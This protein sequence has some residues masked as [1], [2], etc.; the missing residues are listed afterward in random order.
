MGIKHSYNDQNPQSE[1][2]NQN[3][4]LNNE[5][6]SLIQNNKNIKYSTQPYNNNSLDIKNSSQIN[7]NNSKDNKNNK[8]IN[9]SPNVESINDKI[10][11]VKIK[12]HKNNQ[13]WEKDYKK[14]EPIGTII[15]DYMQENN[16]NIPE[17]NFNEINI[18]NKKYYI[19]DKVSAFLGN[20]E[21]KNSQNFENIE[22]NK[23]IK[24]HDIGHLFRKVVELSP[25][26]E[27]FSEL[28][29]KPFYDPFEISLFIK[30]EKKFKLLKYPKEVLEKTMLINFGITSAYCNGYNHLY[31]SGGENNLNNFWII[32]L[33]ENRLDEPINIPPKK[34]HS[35]IYIP[36]STIFFVGG[37]TLDTFYYDIKKNRI[38]DWGNL[39]SIKISPAL[40]VINN[41]L[42]CID[43]MNNNKIN[44]TF[45]VTELTSNEI[46]W[47]IIK[48]NLSYNI[49]NRIFNQQL[50]GVTKD[51][52][53]NIIF[54]GGSLTD[55]KK[56]LNFKYNYKSN[57]IELSHVK[58]QKFILKEKTFYAFNKKYDCIL[59]DFRRDSPQI[60]FYNKKK[61]KLELINFESKNS[62]RN[63]QEGNQ[64]FSFREVN[65]ENRL[66]NINDSNYSE[67][68]SVKNND[69]SSNNNNNNDSNENERESFKNNEDN[70][71]I[72]NYNKNNIFI[73]NN[74]NNND[75]N[76]NNNNYNNNYN[77]SNDNSENNNNYNNNKNNDNNYNDNNYN[78]N[79]YNDDNNNY[80]N[81]NYNNN[82]NKIN[83]ISPISFYK[84][85]NNKNNINNISHNLNK[86]KRNGFQPG[87]SFY[88]SNN[89]YDNN[90]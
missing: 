65:G 60:A 80:D 19:D 34:N 7:I 4:S 85:D 26:N 88:K 6:N 13:I 41:K 44:Y 37:H 75:S 49:N 48:P 39:N 52:D 66:K 8:N 70:N 45:E 50:F 25:L 51:Y 40:I 68:F 77:N 63:M 36:K 28:F 33:K 18:N 31:I 24:Y 83:G 42:Y 47:E 23:D 84:S 56:N 55:N 73:S 62:F 21:N 32:N 57:N 71:N 5:N 14:D 16:L 86:N 35:M 58:Y 59:T 76:F 81:N 87:V 11:K 90:Y 61:G 82:K 9:L 1:N 78:N 10:A 74:G 27:I 46:K 69:N 22:N 64:S 20:N 54:L 67:R 2:S 43:T 29:G 53:D 89:N 38:I 72:N 3:Y 12:N 17:N 79:N 15:K 30:K